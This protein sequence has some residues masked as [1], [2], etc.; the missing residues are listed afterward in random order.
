MARQALTTRAEDYAQWYLDVIAAADMAEHAP[1]KGCMIIKPWGYGIW[2]RMQQSLDKAFKETGHENAYFPLF[3]PKSLLMKEAEHVEG[4]APECAVVTH[5]GGKELEEPLYVR[6]T[7][8]AIICASYANWVKSWRDLPIKLNQW[9]NVVRWEMRT[10]LFLRTTEFLWQEGHTVHETHDEAREEVFTMLDVYAR[11]AEEVMAIPV[12]RGKKSEAEK[13]PG[14][15]DTY[16]IE[17]MMQDGKALQAGTSHDLG[18]NFAKTYGIQFQGRDGTNQHAWSTSWGVSTRLVG[19]L[20]MAHA[21]D[22]GMV[23]PP[24][25]ATIQAVVVP[26]FKGDD[27]AAAM[28]ADAKA[29]VAAMAT[30][31]VRAKADLRDNLRPGPKFFEWEKKGVPVRIEYGARDK[32]AGTCIVVRRDTGEKTTLPV[33]SLATDVPRLLA[34]I[35]AN[36]Y[37]KAKAHRDARIFDVETYDEFKARIDGGGFFRMRFCGDRAV[38]ARIKEETKATIRCFPLD[39]QA[40]PGPCAVTG[41]PTNGVRAIFARAY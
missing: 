19:A 2:E 3:I 10:R 20:I 7:S 22:S 13:F 39:A 35:Q 14:A 28:V 9:A 8:E 33:A 23:V 27:E 18:Q 12:I 31:G 37:A 5:G 16:C 30:A 38:E 1:V 41:V 29:M 6:P 24:L 40:D 26:I 34:E 21:D 36:L 25:L 32:A 17:A 15:D 11:F 4:F